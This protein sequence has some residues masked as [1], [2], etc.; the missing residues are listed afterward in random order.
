MCI[1]DQKTIEYSLKHLLKHSVKHLKQLF[2]HQDLQV[3]G[4]L[5]F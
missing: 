2:K 5:L 1:P 4:F 3:Q